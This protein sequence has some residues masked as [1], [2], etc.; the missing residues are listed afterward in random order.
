MNELPFSSIKYCPN[1]E[2]PLKTLLWMEGYLAGLVEWAV[3][4]C[5]STNHKIR[6][7]K[8]E[9]V[10]YEIKQVGRFIEQ[11]KARITGKARKIIRSE[12]QPITIN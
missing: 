6:L 10:F 11:L 7:V 12:R 9:Q 1:P 4:E 3:I 8:Q 2:K 5:R